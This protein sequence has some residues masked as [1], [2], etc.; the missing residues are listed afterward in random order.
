MTAGQD[1]ESVLPIL[2]DDSL[3]VGDQVRNALDFVQDGAV[4]KLLEKPQRVLAGK[5]ACVGSF[6][7]GIDLMY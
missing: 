7:V 4:G 5:G 1:K 6:Q 3:D 2:V